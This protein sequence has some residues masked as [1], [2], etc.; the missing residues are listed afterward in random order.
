MSLLKE[1][2]EKLSIPAG[3]AKLSLL[4]LL[5]THALCLSIKSLALLLSLAALGTIQ[6]VIATVN[7]LVALGNVISPS[8]QSN[9]TPIAYKVG[10]IYV[11]NFCTWLICFVQSI[12]VHMVHS[13]R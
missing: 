4:L 10:F 13:L 9:L 7:I 2:A 5:G 12:H 3:E 8:I 1:L 11:T 6:S